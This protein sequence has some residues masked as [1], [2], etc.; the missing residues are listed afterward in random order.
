M[1]KKIFKHTP[2]YH[3]FYIVDPSVIHNL[4]IDDGFLDKEG[5]FSNYGFI[6]I[7]TKSEFTEIPISVEFFDVEPDISKDKIWNKYIQCS[8][9]LKSDCIKFESSIGDEFGRL[10]LSSGHYNFRIYFGNQDYYDPSGA[11]DDSYY[12]Q[13]WKKL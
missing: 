13:I 3:Q 8:L 4:D 11:T 10:K 9:E 6:C 12:I 5:Y 1:K 7:A 2:N